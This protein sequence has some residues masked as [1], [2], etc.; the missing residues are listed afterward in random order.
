MP[1]PADNEFTVTIKVH[2][3]PQ[4][5]DIESIERTME[6]YRLGCNFVSQYM[7]D[8]GFEMNQIKLHKVL[9]GTLRSEYGLKSQMAQS[10]IRAVVAR[11]KSVRT[12]MKENP[13]VYKDKDDNGNA[14]TYKVYRDL[15][16][17]WKPINFHRPQVDLVRGR[18][19]SYLS[20]ERK[21]SL[22]TLDGR[23][24]V[25][26]SRN[27]F[28]RYFDGTWTFGLAKILKSGKNWFLHISA[29]KTVQDY[30]LL[31]ET[32]HVVG[33]DRGLRFLAAS[34]DETGKTSFVDGKGIQQKRDRYQAVRDKLQSKG[35]RSAKRALKR[36]SGRENRFMSDVNHRITKTL[37]DTYGSG[38]V[39]VLEDLTGVSFSL[40]DSATPKSKKDK[41]SWAFY[42]FEQ[43]LSYKAKM[44]G[45]MVIKVPADYTSQRC[46]KCGVVRKEN[47]DHSRHLYTCTNCGYRSNDDRIGAMNIQ[48]LGKQY[49]TGATAP[50]FKKIEIPAPA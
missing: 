15:D 26:Y 3:Y 36:I 45:S 30:D 39:F 49:V 4:D 13:F 46:P 33:I 50:K 29:A 2:I 42:Q 32:H 17:F 10:V 9:Y 31:S 48:E 35:T 14:K 8:H 7:F 6:Q 21:L 37:V 16:W 38:T 40:D 19:W 34:Y 12:Q 27:G 18:D 5:S 28:D 43:Y 11:Y 25:S 22:N 23:I 1:M 20:T 24:K 44:N 41:R 47:R